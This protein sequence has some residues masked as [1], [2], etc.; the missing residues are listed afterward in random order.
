MSHTQD[1][2]WYLLLWVFERDD[3]QDWSKEVLL[4]ILLVS[5]WRSL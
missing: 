1:L 3:F 5:G 2:A 4:V